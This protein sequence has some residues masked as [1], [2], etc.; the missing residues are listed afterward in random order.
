MCIQG[1]CV[2]GPYKFAMRFCLKL[3]TICK[4]AGI[5]F[6]VSVGDYK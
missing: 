1:S 4:R 3:Q 5:G 2:K 6:V